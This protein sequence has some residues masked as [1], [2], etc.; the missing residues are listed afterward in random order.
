V[1]FLCLLANHYAFRKIV[2]LAASVA[3]I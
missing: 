2:T 1:L 3:D